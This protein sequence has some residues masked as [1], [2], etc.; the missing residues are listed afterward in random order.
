MNKIVVNGASLT[1]TGGSVLSRLQVNSGLKINGEPVGTMLDGSPQ[2]VGC[3]G[4][5]KF[6]GAPCAPITNFWVSGVHT[7]DKV[8]ILNQSSVLQCSVGGQIT[9][10]DP[11]QLIVQSGFNDSN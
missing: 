5:C 11:G 8:P 7:L 1:C 9:I 4:Y 6:S 2:N 10:I 3:F